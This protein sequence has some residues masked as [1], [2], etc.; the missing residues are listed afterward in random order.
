MTRAVAAVAA[1]CCLGGAVVL[2]AAQERWAPPQADKPELLYVRSPAVVKRT[3][4]SYN[5]IAADVY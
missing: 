2:H 3:A 5:G 1:I 4:L